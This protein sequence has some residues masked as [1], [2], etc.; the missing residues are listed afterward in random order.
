MIYLKKGE[1]YLFLF[2][3]NQHLLFHFL[4]ILLEH[5]SRQSHILQSLVQEKLYLV[6]VQ[7]LM[8]ARKVVFLQQ[9]P[10]Q[11]SV[12]L[13]LLYLNLVKLL[14]VWYKVNQFIPLHILF[15]LSGIHAFRKIYL[16]DQHLQK[17]HDLISISF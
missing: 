7:V 6:I 17:R 12:C 13:E 15:L 11:G 5:H 3:I 4:L 8:L 16:Y 2:L 10:I 9:K 1:K 14:V